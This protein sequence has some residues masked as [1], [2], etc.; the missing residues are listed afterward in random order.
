M[1]YPREMKR[2]LLLA[3]L[4][5]C[6]GAAAQPAPQA[7]DPHVRRANYELAER[8]SAKKLGQMV[9]STRISPNW[10]RDSDKFWYSWKTADGT[11]YWI[12]DPVSG[13][14]TE[15]FDMDRL[16][17]QLTEIVR[18]PFDAQHIPFRKLELK[19]DKKF[20]FQIQSTQDKVEKPDT[21]A[22]AKPKKKGKPEKK[23]YYFEYD[24]ATR[25]LT[26]VTAEKEDETDKYPRWASVSPD[27]SIGIYLKNHNLYWMDK[28]DLAKAVKDEKDST[29]V[30]HPITTDGTK[31]FSWGGGNYT[32]DT[33]TDST[34]RSAV[35]VYW[36]P[37]LSF[38][39]S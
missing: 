37:Q 5:L 17:M 26:D 30:E 22:A 8:F 20:T 31:D 4:M 32:G 15:V 6:L 21:T 29:L 34:K 13:S 9:Y 39:K 38:S 14:K 25:T 7:Q 1:L 27:G 3:G 2:F 36:A 11:R 12:V 33:Q 19:D 18:D 16:A 35:G 23:V 24:I 10:F 28:E